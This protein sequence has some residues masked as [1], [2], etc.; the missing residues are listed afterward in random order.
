MVQI[1]PFL[2]LMVAFFCAESARSESQRVKMDDALEKVEAA[3]REAA[4][5]Q[6]RLKQLKRPLRIRNNAERM[7]QSDSVENVFEELQQYLQQNDE[8]I[9]S[10][11]SEM[12]TLKSSINSVKS[13]RITCIS[14]WERYTSNAY[15]T[16]DLS[17]GGFTA[18]PT[19]MAALNRVEMKSGGVHLNFDKVTRSSARSYVSGKLGTAEAAWIACGKY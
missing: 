1:L 6:M 7:L 12:A 8:N 11:R 2:G 10:L 5:V 13:S 17:S 14:S 15:K 19:F 18:T 9:A 4:D 16:I 3:A